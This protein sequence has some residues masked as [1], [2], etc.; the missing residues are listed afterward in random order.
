DG[1]HVVEILDVELVLTA[2]V[3]YEEPTGLRRENELVARLRA[4]ERAEPSLREA[5]PV[6]RGGIEVADACVPC[7]LEHGTRVVIGHR[8]I[9]VADARGAE[10]ERRQR[11]IAPVGD[12]SHGTCT[13]PGSP[14]ASP[15]RCPGRW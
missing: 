11:Q 13:P 12:L 6:V 1:G 7:G 15:C 10:T 14:P 8:A 9:Q 4:E 3:G 2:G 5:E